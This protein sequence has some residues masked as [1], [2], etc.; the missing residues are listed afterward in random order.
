MLALNTNI[1]KGSAAKLYDVTVV[2]L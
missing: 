2:A 1:H